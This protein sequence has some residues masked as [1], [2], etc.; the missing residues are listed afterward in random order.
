MTS[1]IRLCETK[2]SVSFVNLFALLRCRSTYLII[3][4]QLLSLLEMQIRNLYLFIYLHKRK[5]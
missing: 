1:V 3:E 4:K 2:C 5:T